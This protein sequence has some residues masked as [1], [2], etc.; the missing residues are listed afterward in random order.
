MEHVKQET[1]KSVLMGSPLRSSQTPGAWEFNEAV[2]WLDRMSHG[3]AEVLER[4]V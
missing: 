1:E 2:A 4:S 3:S